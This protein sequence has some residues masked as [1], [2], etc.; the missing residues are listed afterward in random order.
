MLQGSHIFLKVGLLVA[1]RLLYTPSLGVCMVC[2]W[3]FTNAA[4]ANQHRRAGV[5]ILLAAVM[6]ACVWRCQMR[7]IEWR[8][9]DSLYTSALQ[10]CPESARINNNIG[11]R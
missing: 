5:G 2:G 7:N 6:A 10:V 4:A 9:A 11:T 3:M 1:E 8:D